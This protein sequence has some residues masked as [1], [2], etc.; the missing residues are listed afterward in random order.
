MLKNGDT[1]N[2]VDPGDTL[3]HEGGLFKVQSP[4]GEHYRFE[5]RENQS[6]VSIRSDSQ[7]NGNWTVTKISDLPQNQQTQ[8]Q[9]QHTKARA[10][11]QY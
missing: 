3:R 8:E 6:I 9:S 5:C 10:A 4:T 1:L 7:P 2:T 11:G